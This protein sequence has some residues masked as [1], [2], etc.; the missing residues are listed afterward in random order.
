MGMT[1]QE[2]MCCGKLALVSKHAGVVSIVKHLENAIV[3]DPNDTE[4]FAK[5]MFLASDLNDYKKL[6]SNN[7]KKLMVE[8][9][10]WL[11]ISYKYLNVYFK[12]K[13]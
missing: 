10:S 6:I 9:F 3:I 2:A 12:C 7:G 11:A 1:A 13:R 8:Q 5:Y 4:E